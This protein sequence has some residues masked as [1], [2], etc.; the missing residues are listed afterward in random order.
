MTSMEVLVVR[1]TNGFEALSVPSAS[2]VS[3]LADLAVTT[4]LRDRHVDFVYERTLL[5]I[6]STPFKVR[7][8]ASLR[9]CLRSGNLRGGWLFC[10]GSSL[11]SVDP[12]SDASK[13][14]FTD[15]T[16]GGGSV[17]SLRLAMVASENTHAL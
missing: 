9:N 1:H 6:F 4:A 15:D 17:S 2:F 5:L 7:L 3:R 11:L 13:N 8:S 16:P 12:A 14:P 10:L